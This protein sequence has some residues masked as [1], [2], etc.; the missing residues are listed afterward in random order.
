MDNI[1][2][3]SEAKARRGLLPTNPILAALDTLALALS[4]HGHDWTPRE[5]E[6][7][8]SSVRLLGGTT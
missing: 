7:Y 1:I 8:E 2:N 5:I 6:L 4:D 3:L